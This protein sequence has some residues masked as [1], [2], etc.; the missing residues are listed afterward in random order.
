MDEA[1]LI[2]DTVVSSAAILTDD[3]DPRPWNERLEAAFSDAFTIDADSI[4]G[5]LEALTKHIESFTQ[6]QLPEWTKTLKREGARQFLVKLLGSGTYYRLEL[7]LKQDCAILAVA[8]RRATRNLM[9]YA[10]AFDDLISALPSGQAHQ[11]PVL[12]GTP[13]A[14]LLLFIRLD[15][16]LEKLVTFSS[17]A[18]L[19][20]GRESEATPFEL[21]DLAILTERFRKIVSGRSRKAVTELSAALGRKIQGARDALDHS[22][23]PVTQAANSLIELLDRLLRAAF[24][25][26][27]VIEWIG[28]NYPHAKDLTY[29]DIKGAARKLRPTK[30]GQVLCFVY[31]GLAVDELSPL[32]ELAATAVVTVRTQLQKLKHADM[33]TAEEAA[34]VA[35]H[36][37]A[38][39]GFLHLAISV[40]WASM[41]TE[42]LDGLRV[43]LEPQ[44]ADK[45][46][47]SSINK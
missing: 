32:H 43:R 22:A 3:T 21:A 12:T 30:K 41:P 25:D 9:P 37:N 39:E 7:A 28:A 8:L 6:V 35:K 29:F 17:T 26:D 24:S 15:R 11:L 4:N 5:D 16:A 42:R 10:V 1:V 46:T 27:E 2:W 14:L 34:E 18:T 38:I 44:K 31:A 33:G 45:L 40:A 47:S 19:I 20:R 36:L 23:D 13:R